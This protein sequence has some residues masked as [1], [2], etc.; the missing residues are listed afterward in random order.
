MPPPHIAQRTAEILI[1]T[2]AILFQPDSPF[3]LTSGQKSPVY[4]DCRK[5][6]GFAPERQELMKMGGEILHH[7]GLCDTFDVIAGGETAGI[8]YGA[9]MADVLH[10]PMA[11]IRKKPKGFGRGARIE[12]NLQHNDTVLLVEDMT[13]DGGSKVSFVNAIRNAGAICNHCFVVF[14]YGIF[15][16][17]IAELQ[18]K[19]GVTLHYLAAWADVIKYAEQTDYFK[20]TKDLNSVKQFL[21]NPKQWRANATP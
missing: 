7:A 15:P 10:K 1:K 17:K 18:Q 20:N 2:K 5:L 16:D 21:K 9:W 14:S 6:I 11:Y 12:G 3:V 4:V 8:P 19:H 13:T